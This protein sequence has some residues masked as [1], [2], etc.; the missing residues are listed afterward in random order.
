LAADEAEALGPTTMTSLVSQ[1]T[2]RPA[3]PPWNRAAGWKTF[4]PRPRCGA[5]S[6]L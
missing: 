5:A 4:H 3:C 6:H 2:N 1:H